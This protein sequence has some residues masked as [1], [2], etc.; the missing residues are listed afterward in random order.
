MTTAWWLIAVV[1]AFPCGFLA[2]GHWVDKHSVTLKDY[3]DVLKLRHEAQ[4]H[5]DK[6]EPIIKGLVILL[7]LAEK[8]LVAE[9]TNERFDWKPGTG[10]A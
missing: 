2:G 8:G 3:R 1:A 7:A 10:V 4:I 9:K 6:A 5:S